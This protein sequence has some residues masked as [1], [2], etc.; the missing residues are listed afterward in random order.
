MSF[1][2]QDFDP[3]S[4]INSRFPD[5]ESLLQTVPS[6]LATD[7]LPLRTALLLQTSIESLKIETRNV[8]AEILDAIRKQSKSGSNAREQLKKSHE[9]VREAIQQ[10]AR[11]QTLADESE[12]MVSTITKDVRQLDNAKRNLTTAITALRRCA[13]LVDAVEQLQVAA[14]RRHFRD[15]GGLLCAVKQLQAHFASYG[16]IA[17]IAELKGRVQSL[18]Q[19]LRLASLREF[20]LLG[21]DAPPATVVETLRACCTVTGAIGTSARDELVDI[22]CKREMNMY[23]QIFGTIGETAKLERTVN[24]YKW[25]IRRLDSRRVIWGI[26][27]EEWR[28]TQLLALTYCS[29]TKSELAEILA[30]MRQEA[31]RGDVEGLLKAVEA[32]N[33]FEAEMERRF[34]SGEGGGRDE[35][36]E[37]DEDDG[38][39]EGKPQ[40]TSLQSPGAGGV[41]G[42]GGARGGTPAA[43]AIR[44]KY[45]ERSARDVRDAR[46]AEEDDDQRERLQEEKRALREDAA[47]AAVKQASFKNV[48]S[49]VFEPYMYFYAE[50]VLKNL[51]QKL[52]TSLAAE[53]WVQM[54]EDQA[55]LKSSDD[56]TSMIREELRFCSTKISKGKSL[57]ELSKMFGKLYTAYAAALVSK[58]PKTAAGHT[59]GAASL[60]STAWHIKLRPEDVPL[61][62]LFINTSAHCIRM[63]QQLQGAIQKRISEELRDRIDLSDAEDAFGDLT[64][65]SLS[66]LLLGIETELDAPLAV[67]M[68]KN[69]QGFDITGDQSDFAVQACSIIADFG[70]RLCPPALDENQFGFFCD[71]LIRS[72]APRLFQAIFRCGPIGQAGGQQLRLDLEAL[73]GAILSMRGSGSGSGSNG[74]N[75]SFARDVSTAFKSTESVLKVVSSPLETLVDTFMELMPGASQ[76][77][78]QHILELMGIRKIDMSS[79]IKEY[80]T[81]S[82]NRTVKKETSATSATSATSVSLRSRPHI[83]QPQ[84]NPIAKNSFALEQAAAK[85]VGSD[86]DFDLSS[87]FSRIKTSA[88]AHAAKLREN[89]REFKDGGR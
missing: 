78:L 39:F 56:L 46:A 84:F 72:F 37:E 13:M 54:A 66:V 59:T 18:E 27:P 29:I 69:W 77:D 41:G 5:R 43:E 74:S 62:C 79:A 70:R 4:Y 10:V 33:V 85:A 51:Q 19:A 9:T 82:S 75:G 55:I 2:E 11:C 15:A 36:D 8:D 89:L 87:R 35:E 12:R 30:E 65:R 3:V 44:K 42:V 48:I 64:T 71:K 21:E 52:E 61:A 45:R 26:F 32:T 16:H 6:A 53:T 25:F 47:E 73:R 67:L 20:E 31:L 60:G 7:P 28:V 57:L 49:P 50:D 76:T 14:E 83:P 40:P 63:V 38:F 58:L 80:I 23:T 34:G 22:I 17:K 86:F 81:K 88:N 68:R 24:R 1:H